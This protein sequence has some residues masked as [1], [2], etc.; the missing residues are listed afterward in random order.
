[1]SSSAKDYY[2]AGGNGAAMRILP[3]V[4]AHANSQDVEQLLDD[5]LPTVLL[6]MAILEQYL[7]RHVMRLPCILYYK[8]RISYSMAN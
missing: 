1:M 5:V 4:I 8:K 3:H 6:P 2:N 7:V